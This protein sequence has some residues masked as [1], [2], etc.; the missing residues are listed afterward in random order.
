[1]TSKNH[2]RHAKENDKNTL[3]ISKF[4]INH[5]EETPKRRP[6]SAKYSEIES[7]MA[8]FYKTFSEHPDECLCK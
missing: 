1:M 3:N 4:T 6:Q 5:P 8:A 2:H 7:E